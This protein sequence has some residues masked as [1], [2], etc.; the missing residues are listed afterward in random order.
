MALTIHSSFRPWKD[1]QQM[2]KLGLDGTLDTATAPQL[3]KELEAVFK[4]KT[5]IL[6]FDLEKLSFLSSGGVRVI[7]AARKQVLACN[8][9]CM[10]LKLQPQI[11]KTFEIIE[12]L[13]GLMLF[14]DDEALD[15]F[16][17]AL[18][19]STAA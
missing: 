16:L 12:A 6:V 8:G 19:K 4:G 13:D 5:Q 17:S 3:E 11:E 18:Q 2:A 10:M 9:S 7:L 1:G 14:K 15:T